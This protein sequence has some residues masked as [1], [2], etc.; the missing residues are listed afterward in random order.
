MGEYDTNGEKY[1]KKTSMCEQQNKYW[2][3]SAYSNN[4]RKLV[5]QLQLMHLLLYYD[6]DILVFI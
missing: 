5:V 1:E 6:K 2:R 3:I 4:V